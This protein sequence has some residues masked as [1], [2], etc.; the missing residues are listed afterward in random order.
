MSCLI[1]YTLY[2]LSAS[3]NIMTRKTPE[4]YQIEDFVSDESFIN[5][6]FRLNE[7]DVIFWEKWLLAHPDHRVLVKEAKDML[8]SLSLTLSDDEYQDELTKITRAIDHETS[9]TIGKPP[10]IVRLLNWEK[11]SGS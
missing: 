5:Y 3:N 11:I 4:E 10:S 1:P 6:H 2:L 7:D 8:G 9:Q